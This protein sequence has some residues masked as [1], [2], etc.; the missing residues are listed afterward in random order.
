MPDPLPFRRPPHT[1]ADIRAHVERH[2]LDITLTKGDRLRRY[3]IR[4]GKQEGEWYCQVWHGTQTQHRGEATTE[5]YRVQRLKAEYFR[6]MIE[7][8]CD[9]WVK[10]TAP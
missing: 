4:P 1:R 2:C 8:E 9:G 7:L 6:E 5:L 3:W 10:L